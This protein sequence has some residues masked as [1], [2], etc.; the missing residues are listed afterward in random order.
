MAKNCDILEMVQQYSVVV[1]KTEVFEVIYTIRYDE[2]RVP[3][4]LQC[5]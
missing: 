3:R 4:H 2:R 1:D 5:R